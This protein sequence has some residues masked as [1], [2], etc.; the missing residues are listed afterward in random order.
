MGQARPLLAV[1]QPEIQ[2]EAARIIIEEDLNSRDA[3]ELVKQ[4]TSSKRAKKEKTPVEEKR[5]FFLVEMEDRLKLILGTQ[6]RIKQG[7]MKSK[8]EIDYYSPDDLERILECL[9]AQQQAAATKLRGPLV[10]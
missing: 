8:I 4:L 7:K 6:V 5:E 9:S 2:C 3:E 1:E 10:V